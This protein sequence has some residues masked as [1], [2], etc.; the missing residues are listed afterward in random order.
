MTSMSLRPRRS[1]NRTVPSAVANNVSSLPMLTL[2]PGWILVPRWRT[3]IA[4]ELTR[5]PAKTYTPK[6]C[7]CES[8]PLRVDPAPLVFDIGQPFRMEEISS[9]LYF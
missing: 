2:S 9:V 3:K 4:P 5:V 6:R 7:D 1:M 8:R